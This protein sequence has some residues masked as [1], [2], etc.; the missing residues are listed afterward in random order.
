MKI[1]LEK[2]FGE[3]L[4]VLGFF[5]LF[6]VAEDSWTLQLIWTS[7]AAAMVLLGWKLLEKSGAL[8]EE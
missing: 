2:V 8:D 7:S 5:G 6:W 3:I 1:K 4:S